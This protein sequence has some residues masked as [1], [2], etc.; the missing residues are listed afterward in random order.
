MTDKIR[1]SP[2]QSATLYIA[3]KKKTGN[4]GN[5]W[6]VDQNKNGIH[7]WKIFKKPTRI[8]SRKGSIKKGSIKGSKKKGSIKGSIKKGSIKGSIKKGSIKGSKKKGS[9]KGMKTYFTHDNGG[10][11]FM[12]QIIDDVISVYKQDLD[13]NS[14]EED[15]EDTSTYNKKIKTIKSYEKVFIGKD[16]SNTGKYY[17]GKGDDKRFLGNSILVKLTKHKYIYIGNIIYKFKTK[18]EII[19]YESFVGNSDVPYPYAIGTEYTYLMIEDASIPNNILTNF[20]N[21]DPYEIYY[22]FIKNKKIGKKAVEKIGERFPKREVIQ[23][24]IW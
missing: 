24:R 9:I 5:I 19:K 20:A 23:E 14:D 12:V 16:N 11:P 4:D 17:N 6:I 1:P 2:S 13:S 8:G 3:G 7:R 18:D 10:R 21:E 22:N 15:Y